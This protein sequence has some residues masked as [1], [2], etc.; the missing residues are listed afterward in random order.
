MLAT[1]VNIYN[2]IKYN[3]YKDGKYLTHSTVTII[4]YS[5]PFDTLFNRISNK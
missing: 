2:E 4:I 1:Y 5:K 3:G